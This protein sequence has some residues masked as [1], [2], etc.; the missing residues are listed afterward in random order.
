MEQVK[1]FR[2]KNE[3]A[4]RKSRQ[5]PPSS[6]STNGTA[7]STFQR[8]T[9]YVQ[10]IQEA[11]A[12][13]SE[14]I[15]D[16]TL[17]VD[18][19]AHHSNGY[20]YSN[21][22]AINATSSSLSSRIEFS[23]EADPY[24]ERQQQ[25]EQQMKVVG[26]NVGNSLDEEEDNLLNEVYSNKPAE[27]VF[28]V[29]TLETAQMVANRLMSEEMNGR[30]FACDS[31]VMD[32]DVTRQSPCC[33]GRVICF[34]VYAGPDVHFGG[35]HATSGVN[36]SVLY[37]DT[38]LDG[39]PER[40]EEAKE[41]M[42]VFKEFFAS[43]DRN[44]VWH[45]YSF[46]RH[47]MSR[48]GVHN[49]GFAADTMH[50]A[51]L[52][53]SSRMLK[54]GYSLEALSSDPTLMNNNN[55]NRS[56]TSVTS[57]ASLSAKEALIRGKV[58][59]KELFA[60]ANI[61]KDGTEGKLK[62]LAPV[63]EL[64]SSE[65]TKY[66][67]IKYAA[68]D[69]KSTWELYS[70][71][72]R[73]LKN[74]RAEL[75][76]AVKEEF[77]SQGIHLNT[78]FDVYTHFWRSFGE[79]LTDMEA[80]GMTVDREHLAAAQKQADADQTLAKQRFRSWATSKVP[81]AEYMNIGSVPQV[82]QLLFGGASN[83]NSNKDP[84]PL[85]RT[86]KVPNQKPPA[87]D[88]KRVRKFMDIELHSVWGVDNPSPLQPDVYT[89]GGSPACST[90]V[91]KALA[92]KAGRA[93]K[94]LAAELKSLGD[95]DL[96]HDDRLEDD[97][98]AEEDWDPETGEPIATWST[99]DAEITAAQV[100][101]QE[102]IKT[103]DRDKLKEI[104]AQ[105]GYGKLFPEFNSKLEG[106]KACAAVDSLV[107]ASAI[108][109]LLSNFIIPLQSADISELDSTGVW[110]VHCSLNINTETGRLSARRPNLQN[111]PA[112]EKDRY[113]VRRAFTSDIQAGKTLIVADYGQ[114]E[115]RIL[116]HMADCKSMIR[117]FELGGDFHSR[118]AL[119]MYDHIQKAI[120]RGDC[121]LEWDG[122]SHGDD[123]PPA[124]L[125]KDMFA[126][127]RRKAKVLNFSIAYGKTA[128]GLS[129]DWGTSLK[130][131]E[132]T[133]DRWYSDRPE[134][135]DWQKRQRQMAV[136]Q[137]YVCTLLGR[138]R[139][140]PE[141]NSRDKARQSHALRAAINTPIQGSAADVATAAM[142][143]INKNQRLR[144]LG[145]KLL[146]Q[147]HDEVI[148]EGPKESAAEAQALVIEC[149]ETPFTGKKKPLKVDLVVDSKY[150]D[151]WYD[152]K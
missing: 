146:L 3:A 28:V 79:L 109:T 93:R 10:N 101:K 150:A 57:D 82:L 130:E 72:E 122:G 22:N 18:Q 87:E 26:I 119:G 123:S 139:N 70:A 80:E 100:E 33:H 92:G 47:V 95:A 43:P 96:G 138:R 19:V 116:A 131:A 60:K 45:N 108:D 143:R 115:L 111:Q 149:M 53:D 59:M 120:E 129:K 38:Y 56:S 136:D 85:L 83:K 124:P 24:Q 27:D 67:W 121:L 105:Q 71:L 58:S 55:N 63:N 90:P 94:A 6:V 125:L 20:H 152:A 4:K 49:S 86:F 9:H 40:E 135:R 88:E 37:V 51:R 14:V 65:E 134:V 36:R 132:E 114:L 17:S 107:D 48:N 15:E 1:K 35:D 144:E 117:A 32:I 128:H 106:L 113:K 78:M 133:V 73:E 145:W 46:D 2:E 126:S 34:S 23:S 141:A 140:L 97:L 61:K 147:V 103:E 12:A 52:W 66:R 69:A 102:A 81:D 39:N 99:D 25:Q 68:Y 74:M 148:L 5:L 110:R 16:D 98:R 137:G 91:L 112:L 31:E 11:S 41:I 151:T 118:T 30:M 104:A 7:K 62:V 29:D 142:I 64:Q 54:G 13:I 127:E 84:V 8:N 75:D 76:R 21:G 44:K 77:E 50:M 42:A 89:P